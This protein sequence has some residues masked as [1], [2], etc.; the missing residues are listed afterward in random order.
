MNVYECKAGCWVFLNLLLPQGLMSCMC[1]GFGLIVSCH[2]FWPTDSLRIG[3]NNHVAEEAF[4]RKLCD[5]CNT[6]FDEV[7]TMLKMFSRHITWSF[8][9]WK[10]FLF[11]DIEILKKRYRSWPRDLLWN[12]VYSKL[13]GLFPVILEVPEYL[14]L[15]KMSK[16]LCKFYLSDKMKNY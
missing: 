9:S 13:H 4:L 15:H 10:N 2:L 1:I 7:I 12:L 3:S 5:H 8:K 6:S 14:F 16:L 11:Q